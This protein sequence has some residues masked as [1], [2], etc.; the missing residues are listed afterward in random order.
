MSFFHCTCFLLIVIVASSTFA[1]EAVPQEIREV[2]GITEY[3]LE[4]G[5]RVLLF[6]DD[7]RATTTVNLTILVGSRHEG[8]G[9]AGMAHLLEHMVFKGTPNH[10][11]IPAL[12]TE[13]GAR[14][15]GTTWLDRTNYYETFPANVENLET[16]IRLEADRM[17]NSYIKGEDLASEMTVVR[18]EFERGENSPQSVLLERMFGAA[19]EWH[20]Y[21]KSTIG[22]RADIERVPV[23][24]LRQF[25]KRFY[26]PDNAI[27]IVA[28]RFDADMTLQFVQKYFGSIPRPDRKLNQ[29]Y[30]EEPAQDGER[31]VTVRRVGTVPLAGL[32]YHIPAGSHPDFAAID[33]LTT[34]MTSEPAGRLYDSLV[35]R[36]VAASAFG[37]AFGLHDPGVMVF[38][39]EA[40]QGTSADDLFQQLIDGVEG[41]AATQFTPV[42][43][44]R[45]RQELLRQR[46]LAAANTTR[47]AVE[48]SDWAAQ[49]DWRLYFLYR[50]HLEEVTP[51]DVQRV[52][53][54]YLVQSNRT[55]GLFE[56]TA[57]PE[58]SSIPATPDLLALVGDYKGREAISAGESFDPDPSAIEARLIRG[59]LPSGIKVIGLPKKTRG[60]TVELRL[61]LRYGTLESL[62]GAA[63]AAEL[64]PQMLMRG[65]ENLTRQQLSD[66]LDNYRAQMSVSGDAGNLMVS[67]KTT[68][69]NLVPVL[70]LLEEVLRKPVFPEQEL[71]LLQEEQIAA[72]SQMIPEPMSIATRTV[73][74]TIDV[75]DPEDPRY[76]TT[77]EED[78]Q[79]QETVNIEQIRQLYA[80]LIGAS[81][82]ELCVIGDFSPDAVQPAIH[83]IVD[84]WK[85]PVD[86]ERIG[87]EA[88]PMEHG[89]YTQINT[90]DKANAVYFAAMTLPMRDDHPDYPALSIGNFILGGGSL[91][92]RLADRV[93]QK[94]GLSYSIQS[95]MQPSAVDERTAF[96]IFAISNPANA[97]RVH[98]VI[99]EE[100]RNL[101]GEGITEK[102]LADAK[103]GYLNQQEVARSSD[104][105]LASTLLAYAYLNRSMSFI[106]DR[107]AKIASLTVDEVNAAL[108]RY[109]EPERL[110]IVSAGDFEAAAQQ[111]ETP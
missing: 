15:N 73:R 98:E 50:D 47:I 10:K 88:Q 25:Y 100:L 42:E 36:R 11:K 65:S 106:S 52:A 19:F 83:R 17:I 14:F 81:T 48:L 84:G 2:E 70:G 93:R 91:S 53:E 57:S 40:A 51:A 97:G 6:P 59:R 69:E 7:S 33:V 75:F 89:G 79:R 67:I 37:F 109:L 13:M 9:E 87:R 35:K 61:H 16:A 38:G 34:L 1:D 27:L 49:G 23:E 21:G 46:E 3:R 29:T 45:A 92:S 62:M 44:E 60:A 12:L 101:V 31:R 30:T 102:E 80:D 103:K 107:E 68:R 111:S 66:E 54:A 104:S 18:N 4:N 86:Y 39:A 96:Y 56:P 64:L 72:A 108:K 20:N 63:T 95:M 28:G 90:P 24:N 76:V 94:E 55:A 5:L 99:Q 85:S 58:R 8:Y 110:V 71:E 22:N 41:A 78:V 105:R 32:M 77:P 26:Q 43:V 74:R 82:G